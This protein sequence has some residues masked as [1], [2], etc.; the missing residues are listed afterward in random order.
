MSGITRETE[1]MTMLVE[2]LFLLAR[3]DEGRPLERASLDLAEVAAEAVDAARAVEPDRAIETSFEA[4]SVVGDRAQLRQV[5]DNLLANVRAHTPPGTPAEVSLRSAGD[6]VELRVADHGPG[7]T[8]EHAAKVF[9][10]FYRLDSSRARASGGL[11][12][13]LSIVAAIAHAH[14]GTARAEPTP[15]G[16]ATFVVALPR[17][18]ESL[19]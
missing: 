5:I 2:E 3:L 19:Y 11:G 1:R 15:G 17:G 16:G 10:R 18:A 4:A 13:G 12:L 14:E 8:E 7:L 6:R 9:E